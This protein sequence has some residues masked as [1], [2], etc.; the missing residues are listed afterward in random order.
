MRKTINNHLISGSR[1]LL[2][3]SVL[4]IAMMTGLGHQTAIA[5]PA[6]VPAPGSADR[7]VSDTNGAAI[8][9]KDSLTG[10]ARFVRFPSDAAMPSALSPSVPASNQADTFFAKYGGAFGIRNPASELAPLGVSPVSVAGGSQL[11]Y[12]QVFEGVP[13]F[14]AVLKVRFNG[15]NQLSSVNGTFVPGINIKTTTPDLTAR[16]SDN[17]AVNAVAGQDAAQSN[18]R[19][20]SVDQ[21][22]AA[23]NNQ[24]YVFRS[25]LVQGVPGRDH[26]VYEVEVANAEGSVREFVYVDAH[27]GAIVDQITGIHDALDREV[28]ETSLANV[29]WDESA[30]DPDPI[31]GGWAGGTAQQVTDWNNEIDGAKETYNVIAS[32]TASTW[33][34]YDGADATMRT[35]NND[36]GIFCPNANWNGTSTNYCSGVTGDDTVAHEWGHAYTEYTNNLI[37][38][39]QSGALSESYS[40]IWGEVVDFLNGRGTDA[41]GGLRT[42][43]NCSIYG[44]G[45]PSVDDS[46]RWLSGEDDPAFG[47]AIRDLWTPNCYGDPG[48]VPDTQYWCASADSGGVHTNSGVPNHAFALMVDGGSYNGV[49]ITGI[50]TTKAAHIHWGAQ[51]MLTPASNFVDHSDALEQACSDLIGIDLNALDASS[52]VGVPSG[53]IISAADCDEVADAIAATELRTDP[54]QCGFEPLLDPDAPALCAG[55][56]AVQPITSEDW[57]GGSLPAGWTVGTHD[58]A[59]PP[60][61]DTPDWSVVDNLPAD[62]NGTYAAFV[63]NLIIG[64]CAADD[65][66]GA[67]FLDSPPIV[68]PLGEV[69]HLAVDHWVATEAGWDGGNI[70]VRVNGGPW[71]VVPP[72]AFAFN[73]YNAAINGG[74]NTNPLGGEDGFTGT[75]GGEV[76]G[77]WGQSQVNL[78]GLAFAG[79]TV[80]FRFDF[81]VDGCN[82]VIGWYVDD[83]EVYSCSDEEPPICGDG[84]LDLGEMC[85]DGNSD[86]GDGCSSVC[87]VEAGWTCE[88]PT[89]PNPDGT[90]VVADWSFEGG[91]PNADWTPFSTFGGIAGFPLCGP[92]NGCPAAGLAVTGVWN[93]WIGGLS[94]GVTSSVDQSIVIPSTATELT[95]WTLRGLCDDPSDTLHVSLDGSDIGTIVCDATEGAFVEQTF[96]VAG[97]NDDAAHTLLIGGT[98][99]GTNGTHSNFFVDDVSINDNTPT[100]GMPSVCTP[101]LHNIACNAGTVGFEE[102]IP[103]TWT[104]TDNTGLGLVW[105]NIAGSGEPGNYT[106]GEDDAASVS[107]D[108]YGPAD[109]DTELISNVF[110][111]SV[112][113]AASLDYL[114]NYQ[115]FANFDFLD[116]DISSD[117][118]GSWTNLL[119]WNEDHGGFRSPPGEAVSIDLTPWAGMSGLQLRWRYYDPTNFDWVW[120]AQVDNATLSCEIDAVIDIQPG[121]FPNSINVNKKKS[122]VPVA[123]LS[124]STFDA[125]LVDPDTVSF[126]PDGA[127]KA[128]DEAHVEYV[129]NDGLLDLVLHFNTQETGIQCGDASTTL[130][131]VTFNGQHFMASDSVNTVGCK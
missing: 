122:V 39:W 37:Y 128:H 121:S 101:V 18:L 69:S 40:D 4:A 28:S 92:G 115:N 43:G 84:K 14:A 68:L 124:S 36:P 73:A 49:T 19:Q 118:G 79:D 59:N 54:S 26:L 41:P 1:P 81:G 22:L 64:D 57:E 34:S 11:V 46:Y 56:G 86:D 102:G 12:Q 44:Q 120:Y 6:S 47:G 110:S 5:A 8:I 112:S 99:G 2:A 65:E 129:D 107:S 67:L 60:T 103:G 27:T 77:S 94:D 7:L 31:P 45:V 33:L 52:P 71:T 114:A 70:K 88:D 74:G 53:E 23:I 75:D 13:V 48:K 82:G 106:G 72:G 21:D 108:I 61:F 125:T 55:L 95:M 63:P 16:D 89:P 123:I 24:L 20:A 90:N 25:G 62:A 97:F 100:E 87:Q 58:V 9:S 15:Q 119:S 78:A 117:G 3:T 96:S 32:L 98:V 17:I 51:N 35:V 105:T 93:V 76:S 10:L 42:D 29:I 50:G 130:T 113:E 83:F 80:Q 91:V 126:G 116:L 30:G 111:L 38:Q 104:V 127:M 131:G 109:F 85:D 66:S